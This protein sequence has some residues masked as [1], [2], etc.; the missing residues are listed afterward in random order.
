[1]VLQTRPSVLGGEQ[2][3]VRMISL[4]SC[5]KSLPLRVRFY[6]RLADALTPY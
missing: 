1:M 4:V 2:I 6:L 5:R 3:V